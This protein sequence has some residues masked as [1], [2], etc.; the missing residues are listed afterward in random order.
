MQSTFA[1]DRELGDGVGLVE[2]ILSSVT[3]LFVVGLV[4]LNDNRWTRLSRGAGVERTE[5]DVVAVQS[6]DP[7]A[8]MFVF[9]FLGDSRLRRIV[10]EE[11]MLETR[12]RRKEHYRQRKNV[13]HTMWISWN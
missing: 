2:L 12:T 7:I 1:R 9:R 10:M 8:L 6:L 4:K 5:K 13:E 3:E 11:I